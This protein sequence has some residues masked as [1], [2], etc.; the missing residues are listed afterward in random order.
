MTN[1]D[2]DDRW[3][4]LRQ[5]AQRHESGE[6]KASPPIEINEWEILGDGDGDNVIFLPHEEDG[7]ELDEFVV[8][9][10]GLKDLDECT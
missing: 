9:E 5:F 1:R 3:Q 10:R 6:P 8:V 7:V 4:R 2:N